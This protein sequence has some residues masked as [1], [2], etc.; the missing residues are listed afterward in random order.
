M[1]DPHLKMIRE[2]TPSSAGC[3]DCLQNRLELG[4][5]APVSHLR[6]RRLLRFLSA[7]ARQETFP[8]KSPPDCPVLRAGRELALVLCPRGAGLRVMAKPSLLID[9]PAPRCGTM[10]PDP[11]PTTRY[12]GRL[13]HGNQRAEGRNPDRGLI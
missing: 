13:E 9:Y 4:T 3:E 10:E 8:R 12:Q 5:F 11:T 1:A 6:S 2:V 7:T